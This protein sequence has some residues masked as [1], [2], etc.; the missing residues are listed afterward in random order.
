[1]T[2][3]LPF[4][5]WDAVDAMFSILTAGIGGWIALM[6]RKG[7]RQRETLNAFDTYRKELLDF[8]NHVITALDRS[9]SLIANDPENATID[10]GLAK[11]D[12]YERRSQLLAQVSSLIDRGRFL[13]RIANS[14]ALVRRKELRIVGCAIGYS[15]A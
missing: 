13:F 2:F 4:I 9:R 3:E 8:T 7:Q 10:I 1:M 6:V 14:A 15:I 12:Y 5:N 11:N